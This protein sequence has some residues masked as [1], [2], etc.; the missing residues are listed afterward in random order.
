MLAA[1]TALAAAGIRFNAAVTATFLALELTIILVVSALG[2]A[3]ADWSRAGTLLDPV[4]YAADGSAAPV[5]MGTLLAGIVLGMGA[6]AQPR[7]WPR[8]PE[9]Q[10]ASGRHPD[11]QRRGLDADRRGACQRL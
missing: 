1:A 6:Y 4:V 8:P 11:R 3:N 2:F 9:D 10:D 5:G 7:P